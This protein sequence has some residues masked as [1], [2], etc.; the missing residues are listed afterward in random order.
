MWWAVVAAV[1]VGRAFAGPAWADSLATTG[2]PSP[3]DT[4]DLDSSFV[5]GMGEITDFR[6]LGDGR[7]VIITRTGTVYVR[8]AGGGVPVQAGV[9]SVDT[10]SEK[11][12]LGLAVD[13]HFATNQRLY[14][15]YS[16]GAAAPVPGSDTNRHRVVA[17]VLSATNELG[18]EIPLLQNLRGPAN[19]DGGALDVGPDGYLYVGVGDTGNNPNLV[20]E[21]PYAPTNYY[22]TCLTDHPAQLGGGNGKILR[23]ALDG[24]IPPT[25]PLVGAANVTACGPGPAT[26]ISPANLGSPRPEIFAWGFRNPF[27]LWVDPRT[28]LVWAGDVGE[29]AYEEIDVVRPGRHHGWPW[30]EGAHGW[31]TDKCREVRVGTAAGGVP[32]QDAA[33]VE[34]VYVCRHDETANLDP[35]VDGGCRA[36]AGGQIVESCEWPEPFRGLYYFADSGLGALYALAPNE[37]R[38]GVVGGR[39]D[40]GTITSGLP[41]A[42]R[43][44]ND[45]ALYVAVFPYDGSGRIVRIAPKAPAACATTTTTTTMVTGSTTTTTLADGCAALGGAHEVA[46]RLDAAGAGPYCASGPVIPPLARTMRARLDAAATLVRRAARSPRAAALL[47]R[48]DRKLRALVSR[49]ERASRNDVLSAE[50]FGEIDAMLAGLR[51]AI[52][53]V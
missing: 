49:V 20:P 42:L 26:P 17:R 40:V 44:G 32:I 27:R 47:R 2:I 39:I 6:W 52:A 16:A 19:H 8:P 21:P 41:V 12:L 5:T 53:G 37:A 11:G 30:R 45:G 50:C 43:T 34:P 48:A 7:L 28:G 10:E 24:T 33:C 18:P 25:N 9:F 31:P 1:L 13:P 36:I 38:D 35:A 23:I 51:Q 29:I 46:C 4:F 22:P 3:A 14:F 15:Y